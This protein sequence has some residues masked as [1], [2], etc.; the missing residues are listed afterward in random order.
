MNDIIIKNPVQKA[1]FEML[2]D[3]NKNCI[4]NDLELL[5]KNVILVFKRHSNNEEFIVL[6]LIY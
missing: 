2:Y 1:R 3:E 6:A 4:S 5:I